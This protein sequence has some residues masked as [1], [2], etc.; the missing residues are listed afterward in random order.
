MLVRLLGLA[1]FGV[2]VAFTPLFAGEELAGKLVRVG[3]ETVIVECRNDKRIEFKVGRAE[4]R[5]AAPLLG[6]TVRV[7]YRKVDGKKNSVSFAPIF[8]S[9]LR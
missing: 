9:S 1:A 8:S 7:K 6:K 4:R 3:P 2:F 5:Q